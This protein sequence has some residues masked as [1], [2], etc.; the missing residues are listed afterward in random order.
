MKKNVNLEKLVALILDKW[1]EKLVLSEDFVK[2]KLE[3]EIKQV[4]LLRLAAERMLEKYGEFDSN[5]IVT[6]SMHRPEISQ[7]FRDKEYCSWFLLESR[8]LDDKRIHLMASVNECVSL[9]NNKVGEPDIFEDM[10]SFEIICTL[11]EAALESVDE[12][13]SCAVP[14]MNIRR[15]SGAQTDINKFKELA[16]DGYLTTEPTLWWLPSQTKDGKWLNYFTGQD[17]HKL[18]LSGGWMY[19]IETNELAQIKID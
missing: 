17:G 7:I 5:E 10:G 1:N 9:I 11:Y 3:A 18:F 4:I 2:I 6:N 14:N 8:Q 19:N 13:P 16:E 15:L 12:K